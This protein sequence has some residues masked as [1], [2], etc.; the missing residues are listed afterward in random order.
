M[1]QT[2]LVVRKVPHELHEGH[3]RFRG[4]GADRVSAVNRGHPALLVAMIFTDE[5]GGY[6]RV[7]QKGYTHHRIKHNQKIYVQGDVHTQTRKGSSGCSK[8]AF[9]ERITPSR[10][11]GF[12]AT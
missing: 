11:S 7:G 10:R 5:W 9:A 4:L 1:A 8:R 2:G 3:G 6:H 12:R